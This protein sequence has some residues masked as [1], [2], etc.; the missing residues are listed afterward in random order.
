[1]KQDI[2]AQIRY[3]IALQGAGIG[4]LFLFASLNPT[5]TIDAGIPRSILVNRLA[6]LLEIA[7][8]SE[9]DPNNGEISIISEILFPSVGRVTNYL[10][11][12]PMQVP[13]RKTRN[14][15]SGKVS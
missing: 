14:V 15:I 12:L 9:M 3:P 4:R 13:D 11:T 2:N 10:N 7:T 6:A 1:M 5:L 8:P